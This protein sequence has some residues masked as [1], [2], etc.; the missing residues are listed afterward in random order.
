MVE[1][2]SSSC[3]LQENKTIY[4]KKIEAGELVSNGGQFVP[5]VAHSRWYVNAR[6]G[7][8]KTFYY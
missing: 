1:F 4:G 2:K 3:T 8:T 6:D 7:N 5:I